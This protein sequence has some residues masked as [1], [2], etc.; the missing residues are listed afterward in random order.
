MRRGGESASPG[1]GW[2]HSGPASSGKCRAAWSR[3]ARP[4]EA[5]ELSRG[6]AEVGG[7]RGAAELGRCPEGS[8][9]TLLSRIMNSTTVKSRRGSHPDLSCLTR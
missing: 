5:H 2:V 3:Q 1:S 7:A 8:A 6:A 9:L 4:E